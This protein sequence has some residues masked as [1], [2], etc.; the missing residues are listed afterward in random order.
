MQT[1]SFKVT[2][3]LKLKGNLEPQGAKNEALQILC[4]GY[5]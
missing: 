4:V 3:G 1:D 2:G 5:Y